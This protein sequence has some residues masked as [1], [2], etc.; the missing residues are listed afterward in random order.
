LSSP[1]PRRPRLSESN[2][3]QAQTLSR[4]GKGSQRD[5]QLKKRF[6]QTFQLEQTSDDE[7][8]S[9]FLKFAFAVS[10]LVVA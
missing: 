2:G 5:G 8:G 3:G 7:L 1:S 10:K 4:Q 6:S 9:C